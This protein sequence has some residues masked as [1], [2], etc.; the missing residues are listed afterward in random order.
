MG[1]ASFQFSSFPLQ[2]FKFPTSSVQV[3]NCKFSSFEL[4]VSKFSTFKFSTS[5]FQVFNFKFSSFQ[6]QV[7]EPSSFQLQVYQC[8]R[9]PA[10]SLHGLHA[11]GS[12]AVYT[13]FYSLRVTPPAKQKSKELVGYPESSILYM[14]TFSKAH[15]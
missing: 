3:L 10:K 13:L 5:R 11:Q 6:L 4:Q 12:A 8:C 14:R 15:V 7:F 1:I 9:R 2:A